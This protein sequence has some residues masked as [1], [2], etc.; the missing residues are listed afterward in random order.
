MSTIENELATPFIATAAMEKQRVGDNRKSPE[1]MDAEELM[2]IDRAF[3]SNYPGR[4]RLVA[5]MRSACL[6]IMAEEGYGPWDFLED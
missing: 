2:A 6:V 5:R 4:D 3:N 1:Q